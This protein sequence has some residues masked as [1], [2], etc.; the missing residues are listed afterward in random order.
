M[1]LGD[2]NEN[3]G[4]GPGFRNPLPAFF[5]FNTSSCYVV[6]AGLELKIL[7]PQSPRY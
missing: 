2:R 4:K 5:L 3:G 6:Q 1:T 7:L